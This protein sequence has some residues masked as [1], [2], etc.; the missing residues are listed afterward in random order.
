MC[1][2]CK[3]LNLQLRWDFHIVPTPLQCRPEVR[4]SGSGIDFRLRKSRNI[5]KSYSI[6]T[7]RDRRFRCKL[8]ARVSFR[9]KTTCRRPPRRRHQHRLRCSRHRPR[10]PHQNRQEHISAFVFAF[11]RRMS[12]STG[13]I[14]TKGLGQGTKNNIIAKIV[15]L[16]FLAK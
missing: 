2:C 13:S 9:R 12:W 8:F 3:L 5:R 4:T 14:Q 1:W 10:H 7:R 11:H 15:Q 16:Q 6:P